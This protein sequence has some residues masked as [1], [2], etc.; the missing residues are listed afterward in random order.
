MWW[1]GHQL[2][3]EYLDLRTQIGFVPQ[4][5]IQHPQ[6]AVRQSLTY[7][8]KLRLPDNTS[9]SALNR[10]VDEVIAHV[11]LEQEQGQRIGSQLSGGQKKRRLS[12]RNQDTQEERKS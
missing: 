6:L 8:A 9:R 7:S 3:D 5:E 1:L 11:G 4:E 2:H 10:R 12:L